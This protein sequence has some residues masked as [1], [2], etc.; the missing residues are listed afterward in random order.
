[1]RFVD[2]YETLGVARSA[3]QDE[4]KKAYRKLSKKFHPDINKQKG[5]EDKFKQVSEAYEVL[6]DPAKRKKYDEVGSGFHGGQDFRPPSGWQNVDFN[7]G[8]RGARPSGVPEGFSDFF[9]AMF[10]GAA[11]GA[12]GG[13]GGSR[14]R[15]G[16]S[17][18][19]AGGGYEPE[20]RVGQ[21]HE[22]ELTITLEDAYHGATR[23]ITLEQQVMG[24]DG[25]RRTEQRT[26][27]VKIPAGATEG[28]KIRLAGQGGKGASGGADGDLL[29]K[30]HVADHA[31]FKLEGHDLYAVLPLAPWEAVFGAKVPFQTLDGEVQLKIPAGTQGGAKLRLK[32]KGLPKKEGERG[33]LVV[34]LRIVV[35]TAP[36]EAERK[37][38]EELMKVATFK[39]RG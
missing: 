5:A 16:F 17:P 25:G 19:G 23:S 1:M 28:K 35:P 12:G 29:L 3:T 6:K 11:G 8:G 31:R 22:V 34:E 26:L 30:V 20:A 33:A 27:Q 32:E 13:A 18:F 39:P 21:M 24:S 38:L 4:I 36:T 10:G 15:G 37:A 14:R 2:Y 7:F 9:E